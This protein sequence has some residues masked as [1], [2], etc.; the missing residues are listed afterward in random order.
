MTGIM[1]KL[2]FLALLGITSFA[3]ADPLRNCL[4]LMDATNQATS[5]TGAITAFVTQK[6]TAMTLVAT[7]ANVSGTSPTLDIAIDSCKTASTLCKPW[8]T[9]TQCT[10]GSCW[11]SGMQPIDLNNTTVN[12]FPYFRARTTLAGTSPVYNVKIELCYAV[13]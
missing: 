10:T 9:F 7:A 12:W 3:Q 5:T 4:T 2:L 11:T 13:P 8:Q 1:K 6:T